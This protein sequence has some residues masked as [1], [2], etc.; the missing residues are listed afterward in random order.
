MG[1]EVSRRGGGVSIWSG[2]VGRNGNGDLGGEGGARDGGS[3][4]GVGRR[5]DGKHRRAR[6]YEAYEIPTRGKLNAISYRDA[7]PPA[8]HNG[9]DVHPRLQHLR[10][11]FPRREGVLPYPL[12]IPVEAFVAVPPRAALEAVVPPLRR[13]AD[14]ERE[15][16]EGE[17]RPL[18]WVAIRGV[19]GRG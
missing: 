1:A 19:W 7:V 6:N 2:G 13:D 10:H 8:F 11:I 5:K 16:V 15:V 3:N 17:F 9:M 14:E 18:L 4:R 12:P